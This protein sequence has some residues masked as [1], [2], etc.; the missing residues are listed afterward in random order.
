MNNPV[1]KDAIVSALR[2]PTQSERVFTYLADH[3]KTSAKVIGSV[4][5]LG[6]SS[7]SSVVSSL[8]QR[9]ILRQEPVLLRIGNKQLKVMHYSTAIKYYELLPLPKTA[10]PPAKMFIDTPVPEHDHISKPTT[11]SPVPTLPKLTVEAYLDKLTLRE[12]RKA[13]DYLCSYFNTRPA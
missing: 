12:A 9:G 8:V 1:M 6:Y 2:V 11:D 4:L 10:K 3:P 13:Y 7:S 5:G